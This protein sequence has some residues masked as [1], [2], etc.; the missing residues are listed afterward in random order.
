MTSGGYAYGG[1]LGSYHLAGQRSGAIGIFEDGVN[2]NDQQAG[3]ETVKPLQNAV[4]E[5]R[6][7]TTVPPAEY[8]HSAGG[9]IAL[10][11]ALDHPQRAAGLVLVGTASECNLRSHDFYN[12]LARRASER[13]MPAVH[14]ALGL[15]AATEP[16]IA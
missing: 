2:G 12:D 13:G 4:A 14:K 5:V 1:S 7:L 10:Q 3:T 11:F 8:G 6:V 15:T 16:A 9:V